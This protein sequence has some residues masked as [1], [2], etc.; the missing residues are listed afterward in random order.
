MAAVVALG[1]VVIA[2]FLVVYLV[3][4][5]N[6]RAEAAAYMQEVSIERGT[7]LY[8]QYCITC[9]GPEGKGGKTGPNYI[10]A[11]LDLAVN[12]TTDPIKGEKRAEQL[13]ETI[14][15]GRGELPRKMPAWGAENNGPL[16]SEQVDDLVHMIRHGDW[17]KVH[18]EALKHYKGNIPTPTPLPSADAASE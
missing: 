11:P 18:E 6:R 10:G 16:N 14:I 15:N 9:H 2:T 5:P 1:L 8:V 7:K 3:N 13:K 4:E 12:T 17:Q